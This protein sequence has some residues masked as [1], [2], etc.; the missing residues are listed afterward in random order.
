M[1]ARVSLL[2]ISTFF[3]SAA[4]AASTIS[5]ADLPTSVRSCITAQTCNVDSSSLFNQG[6]TSAF[7]FQDGGTNK[8]L[9]R[10]TLYAPS[11]ENGAPA[12]GYLWM[13]ANQ[14][15]AAAEAYH[16]VTLYTDAVTP[17]PTNL[18]INNNTHP[19]MLTLGLNSTDL[20][21]GSGYLF[22][23]LDATNTLNSSGDL[24]T[25]ADAGFGG[26]LPCLAEGCNTRAQ[27]NLTNLRYVD[28]GSAG[29][30]GF[31]DPT[32]PRALLYSQSSEY[33]PPYPDA[34]AYSVTQRYF[35][36][37]VPV[38]PSAVLL[39]SGLIGLARL[40]RARRAT[41]EA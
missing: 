34:S 36:Q 24:K 15:Y 25:Y 23:G 4:T 9:M 19:E 35:V 33:N 5:F 38:P 3:S 13:S 2:I 11:G 31:F 22:F 8:W 29:L 20:I 27:L 16:I 30:V 14:Q 12:N 17:A 37:P 39:V 21:A 7:Q 28:S 18:W 40:G 41:R 32:D 26:L 6:G 1:N 10:Y